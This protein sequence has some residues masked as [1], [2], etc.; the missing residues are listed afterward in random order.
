[1]TFPF[2]QDIE[3]GYGTVSVIPRR[4]ATLAINILFT[5]LKFKNDIFTI[6]LGDK[7]L[8]QYKF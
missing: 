5:K 6:W 8:S 1:M 4:L 7:K 3:V 2:G